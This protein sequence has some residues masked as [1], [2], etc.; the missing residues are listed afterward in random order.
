MTGRLHLPPEGFL[1]ERR[2]ELLPVV[3]QP[4]FADGDDLFVFQDFPEL[5]DAFFSVFLEVFRVETG[6]GVEVGEGGGNFH[7]LFRGGDVVA[8]DNRFLDPEGGEGGEQCLPVLVKPVVVIVGVGVKNPVVA[9]SKLPRVEVFGQ[10]DRFL[11]VSSVLSEPSM[12]M[13]K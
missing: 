7:R 13:E 5:R 2:P 11:S 3:V 1:L 8:D 6:G 10:S 9:G 12:G 4:D